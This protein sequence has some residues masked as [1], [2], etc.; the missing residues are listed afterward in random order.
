MSSKTFAWGSLLSAVVLVGMSAPSD[1]LTTVHKQ[2]DVEIGVGGRMNLMGHGELSK[3][4]IRDAT[5]IYLFQ[6]NSRLEFSAKQGD[7]LFYSQLALGGEDVYSSNN[8]LTL[9]DMYTKIPTPFGNV[10]AGQYKVPFG[11]EQLTDGGNL[12]F[13]KRSLL[14]MGFQMGRDYG[15]G[16][17]G[18]MGPVNSMVGI[19]AGGGRDVPERYIPVK[20]GVPLLV[21]RVGLGELGKDLYSLPE[22][23]MT[24]GPDGGD[25]KQGLYANALY[26]KNTLVG[27]G[28]V[29]SQRKFDNTILLNANW[30]PYFAAAKSDGEYWAAGIDYSMKSG[31]LAAEAEVLHGQFSAD[32]GNVKMSGARAQASYDLNPLTLSLRYSMLIPDEKFAVTGVVKGTD[33]LK[34]QP[35][36]TDVKANPTNKTVNFGNGLKPI[37]EIVPAITW[38]IN[39]HNLKLIADLP[40]QVDAP[41]VTEPGIGDYNLVNQPDQTGYLATVPGASIAQQF[42]IQGRLGLQ[43]QF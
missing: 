11:G 20:M 25:F 39:G 9:L 6:K 14:E 17:Q 42:I 36:G 12:V 23:L 2:G 15:I 19:Y 40:I 34:V 1:A 16:L 5:K 28:S 32:K 3:D 30:N 22:P 37:H 7:N 10:V 21:A 38:H 41:V 27:H 13:N 29:L 26:T 35:N 31:P 33:G 4:T 24:Q 43:Y 18:S 8:N